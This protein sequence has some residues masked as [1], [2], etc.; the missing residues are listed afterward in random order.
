MVLAARVRRD[1][2]HRP[3]PVERVQRDEVVEAV[4]PDLLQRFA[5]ALGLELED[6]DAVAGGEHRVGRRVIERQCRH[7]GPGAT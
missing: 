3:R 7:V 6:A 4:G 5:H 1:L 2:V